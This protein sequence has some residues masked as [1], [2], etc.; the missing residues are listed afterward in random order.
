MLQLFSYLLHLVQ[1]LA[2][3]TRYDAFIQQASVTIVIPGGL[4][5]VFLLWRWEKGEAKHIVS[6]RTLS[7]GIS[8]RSLGERLSAAKKDG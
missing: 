5:G 3:H 1:P 8:F 7:C 6:W 4:R 2:Y